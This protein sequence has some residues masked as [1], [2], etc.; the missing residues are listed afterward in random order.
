[1]IECLPTCCDEEHPPKYAPVASGDHL[2][3]K[4]MGPRLLRPSEA[5]PSYAEAPDVRRAIAD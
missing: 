2:M 3:A 4:L 5:T 1:V